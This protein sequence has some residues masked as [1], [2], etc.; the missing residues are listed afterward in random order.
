MAAAHEYLEQRFTELR[1]LRSLG[2]REPP[3]PTPTLG[4]LLREAAASVVNLGTTLLEVGRWGAEEGRRRGLG[5]SAPPAHSGTPNE[6]LS[7][8]AAAGGAET[9]R[10]RQQRGPRPGRRRSRRRVGPGGPGC[11]AGHSASGGRSGRER[12]V[13]APGG[14]A[15]PMRAGSTGVRL[16]PAAVRKPAGSRNGRGTGEFGMGR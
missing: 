15:V 8:V 7:P 14:M 4:L 3:A 12:T 13:P 9:R 2:P 6:D 10:R 11:G 1:S 5:T 16:T